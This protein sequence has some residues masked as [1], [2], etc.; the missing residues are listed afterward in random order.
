MAYHSLFAT[1]LNSTTV[2]NLSRLTKVYHFAVL[3]PE[4]A[5]MLAPPVSA[6]DSDDDEHYP[7]LS[8]IHI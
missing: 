5:A 8:L 7:A 6:A 2:D 1:Y 4:N 3:I